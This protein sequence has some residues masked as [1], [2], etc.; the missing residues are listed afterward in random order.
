MQRNLQNEKRASFPSPLVSVFFLSVFSLDNVLI[1]QESLS[2]CLP[3]LC[4]FQNKINCYFYFF[5]FSFRIWRK[6][7][8]ISIRI[9]NIL[10]NFVLKFFISFFTVIILSLLMF[11][12]V[13]CIEAGEKREDFT[14]DDLDSMD[15]FCKLSLS[16]VTK[17]KIKR[18]KNNVNAFRNFLMIVVFSQNG[19]YHIWPITT[20]ANNPLT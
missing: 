7:K 20:N 3:L 8:S 11:L 14:I 9:L 5:I 18:C 15:P 10:Q 19:S 16:D 17:T 12:L 1:H 4:Y 6:F 2:F 13:C